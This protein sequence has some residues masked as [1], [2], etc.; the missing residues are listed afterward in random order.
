MGSTYPVLPFGDDVPSESNLLGL[1]DSERE[2]I[3]LR[4]GMPKSQRKR[5]F[6]HELIHM[7]DDHMDIGLNE[8]QTARLAAGLLG[9]RIDGRGV[10]RL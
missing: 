6:L 2:T 8:K 3:H 10:I 9:V 1:F 4:D 7:V 5:T